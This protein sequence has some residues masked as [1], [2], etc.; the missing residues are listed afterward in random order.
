MHKFYAYMK[1]H[2]TLNKKLIGSPA[3]QKQS[4]EGN[5]ILSQLDHGRIES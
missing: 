5:V 2:I 4:T 1:S 3:M